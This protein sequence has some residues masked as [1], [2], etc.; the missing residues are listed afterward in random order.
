MEKGALFHSVHL[1]IFLG[2]PVKEP[3]SRFLHI[4]H[5]EVD[6]VKSPPST[7]QSPVNEPPTGT[8]WRVMLVPRGFL[9]ISFT[10]PSQGNPLEVP[11]RTP[12]D[13]ER[14]TLRFQC[15]PSY[16]CQIPR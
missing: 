5:R 7:S 4:S 3:S 6:H 13:R 9:Y 1:R 11:L 15:P 2:F 14:E 8:L 16:D 10:V 12:I